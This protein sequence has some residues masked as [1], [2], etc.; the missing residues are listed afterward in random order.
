MENW[1]YNP[2]EKSGVLTFDGDMTISHV[3]D[4]KECFLEAFSD[5]ENVTVDV[6]AA[7]SVDVAGIQLLCA[8]LRFSKGRGKKMS[9][10]LGENTIFSEFLDEVGFSR[11]FICA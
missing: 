8:C 2:E 1:Q 10:R 7:T 9:L 5:A 6:S 3:S 4:I 11:D